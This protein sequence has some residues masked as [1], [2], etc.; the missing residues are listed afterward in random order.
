MLTPVYHAIRMRQVMSAYPH[1]DETRWY[2][3]GSEWSGRLAMMRFSIFATLAFW[4]INPR[5][6]LSLYLA[7]CAQADSKA[8]D[9][10][11]DFLPWDLSPTRL[12][13]LQAPISANNTATNSS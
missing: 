13:E 4:K 9:D 2:G 3:S 6:W 10:V 7:A 11:T 8:P 1:A 5:R 12:S